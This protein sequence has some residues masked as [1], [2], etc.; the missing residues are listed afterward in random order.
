MFSSPSEG[1]SRIINLT[2]YTSWC[3]VAKDDYL[4]KAFVAWENVKPALNLQ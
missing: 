1:L 2:S 3:N 4:Y